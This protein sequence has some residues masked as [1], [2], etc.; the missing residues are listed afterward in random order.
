MDMMVHVPIVGTVETCGLPLKETFSN[1]FLEVGA[2]IKHTD[3]SWQLSFVSSR[4]SFHSKWL[5]SL[6][7]LWEAKLMRISPFSRK[8]SFLLAPCLAPDWTK[9]ILLQ[10][11]CPTVVSIPLGTAASLNSSMP[12]WH[13]SQLWLSNNNI[14]LSIKAHAEYYYTQYSS[15][16]VL[17]NKFYKVNFWV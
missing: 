10:I 4:R 12:Y 3:R 1:V 9:P 16:S 7:D 13:L 2:P 17:L 14:F 15:I 6:R 11:V 8:C 5:Q